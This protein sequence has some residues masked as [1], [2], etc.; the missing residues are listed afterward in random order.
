MIF[1]IDS[2]MLNEKY[3]KM[4]TIS[5]LKSNW[6]KSLDDVI[7]EMVANIHFLVSLI[8]KNEIS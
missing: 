4:E 7:Q 3:S 2:K 6:Q 5:K 8:L 1:I